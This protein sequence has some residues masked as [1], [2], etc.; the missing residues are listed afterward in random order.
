M[1]TKRLLEFIKKYGDSEF[2]LDEDQRTYY[3]GKR[4]GE[5]MRIMNTLLLPTSGKGGKAK[6]S[7]CRIS[8]EGCVKLA[9]D[10]V[11]RYQL[12]VATKKGQAIVE[13]MA[14]GLSRDQVGEMV[15]EMFAD[16]DLDADRLLKLACH[17]RA[18]G[19]LTADV[20]SVQSQSN[21]TEIGCGDA[22]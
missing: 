19:L 6:F 8:Y 2:S 13:L 22:Q 9:S 15:G 7:K 20:G 3:F 18:A 11:M 10:L 16:A 5:R 14:M 4:G 17:R 21:R 12:A 1:D